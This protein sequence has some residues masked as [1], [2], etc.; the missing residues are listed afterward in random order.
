MKKTALLF[1]LLFT[2]I[3]LHAQNDQRL[4]GLERQISRILEATNTPGCAI[5][6]VEG[7]KVLYTQGFG[8]RDYENKVKADANTLFSV[9]STTKAFTA[10]LVG[11]LREK[12]LLNFEESPSK[13]VPALKFYN[14]Q[15][16]SGVLIHDLLSM[17]TGLALHDKAWSGDPVSDRDSL[18]RRIE[19]LEPAAPLRTKWNY[20]NFSYFILGTITEKITGKSWEENVANALFKPLEMHNSTFGVEGLQGKTNV[21]LG[22]VSSS[23]KVE[24]VAYYDLAAMSPAGGINSNAHDM[25]NWLL[26]WLNMGKY[27]GRQILPEQYVKEAIS[28]QAVMPRGYLPDEEFPGMYSANYGYGWIISDYKGH[29]RVEH[30]GSVDGFRTSVTFFPNEKIGIVVLTNQTDYEPALLIRNTLVDKLL[31]VKKTD[32]V[33]LYLKSQE[34]SQTQTKTLETRTEVKSEATISS[35]QLKEFVGSYINPGYGKI[36]IFCEEDSLYTYFRRKKLKVAPASTNQD[37]FH[38]TTTVHPYRMAMPPLQFKKD[39]E[40]RITSLSIQFESELAAIEF[41]KE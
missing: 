9:G 41:I 25:G 20:S 2:R 5:A 1:L 32:W 29:Y 28:P 30:G 14:E 6:I 34:P 15:L 39:K 31:E 10:A 27:K 7:E 4:R 8:Y 3:P 16:N 18:L 11:Q 40:G 17:R 38:A 13:Y 26:T 37:I 33:D 19:Y 22:Y 21:S 24:K 35:Q 36:R 12:G 23:N